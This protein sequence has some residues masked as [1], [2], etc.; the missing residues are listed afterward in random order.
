MQGSNLLALPAPVT[1]GKV[2]MATLPVANPLSL[3]L[4]V[5]LCGSHI[6]S[7]RTTSCTRQ[8][9]SL[10]IL[11]LLEHRRICYRPKPGQSSLTVHSA[12]WL[13]WAIPFPARHGR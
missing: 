10:T 12:L 9:F 4:R 8:M 6:K 3:L 13:N 1:L 7:A 5:C 11:L 2:H